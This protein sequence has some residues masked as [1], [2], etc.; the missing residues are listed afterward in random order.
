MFSSQIILTGLIAIIFIKTLISFK[1]NALPPIFM[2]FW[3]CFWAGI[4][5]LIYLPNVLTS[6]AH[7]L[8]IGRGVDLAVYVSIIAIFY[9][10]YVLFVRITFLENKIIDLIRKETLRTGDISKNKV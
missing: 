3:L 8:G 9:T 4:L 6:L 10:I 2:L 5:V 1:R 7:L